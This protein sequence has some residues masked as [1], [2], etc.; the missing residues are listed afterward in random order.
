MTAY[1]DTSAAM[2]LIVRE[3]ESAALHRHVRAIGSRD[4]AWLASSWLLYAELHCAA[5]RHPREV[6]P[7]AIDALLERVGLIELSRGDL[8]AVAA[9]GAPLRTNDAIHLAVALR[10]GADEII[11]YDVELQEAALQAGIQ[12]VA[13]A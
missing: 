7:A 2:K 13:P 1:L 12:V 11:T 9:L 10:V 3:N 8:L 4:D 5:R 6:S